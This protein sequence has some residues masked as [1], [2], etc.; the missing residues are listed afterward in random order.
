[1]LRTIAEQLRRGR[2]AKG[3]DADR[4]SSILTAMLPSLGQSVLDGSMKPAQA[5]ELI[6]YALARAFR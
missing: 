5:F 1:M 2:L 4:E 6:D 3:V